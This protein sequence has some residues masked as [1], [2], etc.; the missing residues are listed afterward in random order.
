MNSAG[1]VPDP[2]VVRYLRGEESLES[3]AT[4]LA[5]VFRDFRQAAERGERRVPSE[6]TAQGG[7]HYEFTEADHPKLRAL[8]DLVEAKLDLTNQRAREYLETAGNSAF[9]NTVRLLADDVR[10]TL[11]ETHVP[12][13][14]SFAAGAREL[15]TDDPS[16]QSSRTSNSISRTRSWTPRGPRALGIRTT[17]LTMPTASG[18][19]RETKQPLPASANC[20]VGPGVR[21]ACRSRTLVSLLSL[22]RPV[23]LPSPADGNLAPWRVAVPPSSLHTSA[24][25]RIGSY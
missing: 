20:P 23:P 7:E 18:I 10:A 9:D 11:G 19:A 15:D 6:Q 8:M 22:S 14:W 2:I 1:S 24:A 16:W 17:R 4:A 13:V 3:T 5:K 12:V 21:R 25:C